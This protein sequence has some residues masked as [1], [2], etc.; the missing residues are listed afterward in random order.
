MRRHTNDKMTI[1]QTYSFNIFIKFSLLSIALI[2]LITYIIFA[3][4]TD[5]MIAQESKTNRQI[6][7]STAK[8]MEDK[9]DAAQVAI[10]DIYYSNSEMQDSIDYMLN[11]EWDDYNIN[12]NLVNKQRFDSHFMST[13]YSDSDIVDIVLLSYSGEKAYI[14]SKKYSSVQISDN[15][16]TY[17]WV[18]AIVESPQPL[19]IIPSYQPLHMENGPD[20]VY[21]VAATLFTGG[22]TKNHT[23]TIIINYN[24]ENIRSAYKIFEEDMK[25]E[26]LVLDLDGR[27]V[28]DSS[29]ENYGEIYEVS[30]SLTLS[31]Q[32]L[33][34][35][36]QIVTLAQTEDKNFTLVTHVS[37]EELYEDVR[38]L[39]YSAVLLIA[40]FIVL[41]LISFYFTSS[42]LVRRIN[43]I[44]NAIGKV[45]N[46]DLSARIRLGG[47]HR[48]ELHSISL[49][50]N[51]MLSE[52]DDYI[53]RNYLF[54][55]KLKENELIALQTQINPHF[56]YNTLEIIRVK[57][58][59]N[60]NH[61]VGNMINLLS[62]LFRRSMKS[63]TIV[64]SI[65]EELE[66]CKDYLDL[67]QI[68]FMDRMAISYDV[69]DG[70]YQYGILK[71]VLQPLIENIIIHSI[72]GHSKKVAIHLQ[73]HLVDGD[74][75]IKIHDTGRG[76]PKEKL[77][78]L[79]DMLANSPVSINSEHIGLKNVRDRMKIVFGD[80]YG[81]S[82]ESVVDQS[83][84]ITL[85]FPAMT[86]EAMVA[87][88]N[89]TKKKD[90]AST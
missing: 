32:T 25:G 56:I 48:D 9:I 57:A 30:R 59:I 84:E 47:R 42:I 14:F 41:L 40:V 58:L 28:F 49:M 8:Y 23:G 45:K 61:D 29:G 36:N 65:K 54:E 89:S 75:V 15:P 34:E 62:N 71:S 10:S 82:I 76:I 6:M 21:S 39:V 87:M 64:I 13:L 17:A 85:T 43:L 22:G 18:E 31:D 60:N 53:N 55:L 46:G 27:T 38:S 80:R 50:F 67:N 78:D 73:G 74:V 69:D 33:M 5:L 51:H 37:R 81:M 1:F 63:K 12:E 4:I 66:Y 70:L 83:T 77:R 52:L 72:D 7:A 44:T 86:T 68:R 11:E 19:T 20:N 16:F 79:N 35:D 3:Q 88:I 2:V 90:E 26:I 24:T